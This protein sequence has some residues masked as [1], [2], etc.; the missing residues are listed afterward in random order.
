MALNK[1]VTLSA[2]QIFSDFC[3]RN[4][5]S[6]SRASARLPFH[7]TAHCVV[8]VAHANALECQLIRNIHSIISDFRKICQTFL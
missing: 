2:H 6:P 7:L 4:F 5:F 1:F 3:V 8:V